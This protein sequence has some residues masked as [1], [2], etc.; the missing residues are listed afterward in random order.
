MA[1]SFPLGSQAV[2]PSRYSLAAILRTTRA[3]RGLSQEQLRSTLEARHLH[4]IEH[5][6]SNATLE[7]LQGISE[8][9]DVDLV[10]LMA[11]AASYERGETLEEF[12]TY[13]WSELS[14]LNDLGVLENVPN[15]FLDGELIAAKSGKPSIPA[16]KIRSV[17]DCK[18]KG[19]TQKETSVKLGIP[20]STVHKIWHRKDDHQ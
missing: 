19:L 9:L 15:Q 2:M 12:M 5:A 8:Q 1:L 10:A 6:K 20:T 16:E 7:M 14:K 17:L 18:A 3:A 11:A 13:L 4:N